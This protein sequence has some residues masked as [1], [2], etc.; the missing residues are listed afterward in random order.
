MHNTDIEKETVFNAEITCFS[1]ENVFI[2]VV[3]TKNRKQ[4]NRPTFFLFF[5]LENAELPI[6]SK[7][8]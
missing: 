5:S 2:F 6:D 4:R 1:G 7:E 8:H 3:K